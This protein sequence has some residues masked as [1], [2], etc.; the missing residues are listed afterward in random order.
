VS[1]KIRELSTTD[2]HLRDVPLDFGDGLN[3]IIGA[4]GTCKSTII[5]TIRFLFDDDPE[6]IK[7]L[8]GEPVETGDSQHRG[9]LRATLKGGTARVTLDDEGAEDSEPAIER[10]LSSA[11]RIYADAV[12]VLEDDSLLS[13]VE[14]YSQGELQKIASSAPMRLALI[15][16]PNKPEVDRRL[17]EIK[18]TAEKIAAAG[19]ELRRLRLALETARAALAEGEPIRQELATLAST[20]P[21]MSEEMA[22]LRSDFQRGRR[23]ED[24]ASELLG[25]HE[26]ALVALAED[27]E[28]LRRN[29]ER[30]AELRD[31]PVRAFEPL[32]DEVDAAAAAA[33]GLLADLPDRES[34]RERFEAGRAALEEAAGGYRDALRREEEAAAAVRREDRLQEEA[35]KLRRIEEEID[36]HVERQR[37]LLAEREQMRA[38][39]D[40]LREEIYTARLAEVERIN[41]E[42]AEKIVL[43][44]RQG[45]RTD[46]YRRELETL[47]EGSW[48]RDRPQLCEE[49]AA[50]FPPAALISAVERDDPA[51]LA[52]ALGR[53]PGQMARLLSHLAETEA[54]FALESAV[55]DDELEVTMFIDGSPRSVAEM[56]N[57]ERA[58]AILPLLLRDADYPLILD[59][60]EDDL[61]NRFVYDTLV[62]TVRSLKARRQLI[63][64]THNANIPVI[65]EAE[66]VFVM[67]M[68]GPELAELHGEGS[69][70]E[71]RDSVIDLLEG[72]R[73][74]FALR[75]K[76]YGID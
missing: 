22:T 52:A 16:R 64:A 38:H 7:G 73:Q 47:L 49:L 28:R 17:G 61:D 40:G 26:E 59:Q 6:R 5:E 70:D 54:L 4:R 65:G 37:E 67:G 34:A 30:G 31:G 9:L 35:E 76:T 14:I 12:R 13:K 33:E 10:D 19:P 24:L 1:L 23:V 32:A 42:F 46:A 48:L 45:T 25:A 43:S 60:P 44:L 62:Q 53:D 36:D 11:P 15:D 39:L 72:G 27:I 75:S 29:S 58:T 51:E 68:R 66:R 3:C 69:V 41:S 63:F 56:S 2:G 74:A 18:A 50:A 55:P 20:R 21:E 8:L 57:G 71:V